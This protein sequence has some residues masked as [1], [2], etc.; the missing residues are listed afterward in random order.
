MN[1]HLY[2]KS[3]DYLVNLWTEHFLFVVEGSFSIILKQKYV[4][5]FLL[6]KFT[7]VVESRSKFTD[8]YNQNNAC[9]MS[10]HCST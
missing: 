2:A 10:A 7:I 8:S 1:N 4:D 3:V 5:I 6:D 9:I